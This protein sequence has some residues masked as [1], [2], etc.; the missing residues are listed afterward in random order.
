M[1]KTILCNQDNNFSEVKDPQ[2]ISELITDANHL[3]W[4]DLAEPTLDDFRLLRAEFGLHPLAIEDAMS[5]HQRPKVEQYENFYFVVF[6]A[7]HCQGTPAP[8]RVPGRNV[9]AG[10]DYRRIPRRH[11]LPPDPAQASCGPPRP[12]PRRERQGRDPIPT[13]P[14]FLSGRRSGGR[15]RSRRMGRRPAG[16]ARDLDVHG[17]E[18]ADHCPPGAD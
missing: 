7:V 8:E 4:L 18:L 1:L 13:R 2:D 5:R 15:S 9:L 16:A 14:P 6:Y 10:S 12:A 11:A 3:V 17:G